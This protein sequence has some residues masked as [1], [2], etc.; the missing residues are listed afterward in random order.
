[1]S[2]MVG[3]IPE[4]AFLKT[5]EYKAGC[6]VDCYYLDVPESVSLPDYVY[7]FFTSPVFRIER[8]MLRLFA[9]S[10]S[11][12][13]D[14]KELATNKGDRLA[15]WRA[16]ARDD[17]QMILAVGEGPIRTWF[18]CGKPEAAFEGTRLYFGSAVLPTKQSD[19]GKPEMGRMFRYLLG[20]HKIYS[21]V[22]LRSAKRKLRVQTYRS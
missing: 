20:F 13:C 6:Y 5:Y 10:Q 1:M 19:T 11:S 3:R 12:D 2:V 15:G 4:A 8:A 7:A 21:R 17:T 9:S 22:L 14:V 16:M 18:M